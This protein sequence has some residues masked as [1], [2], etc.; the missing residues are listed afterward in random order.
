MFQSR[1]KAVFRGHYTRPQGPKRNPLKGQ[2]I[3]HK[4]AFTD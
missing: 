2:G 1:P 3:T 4:T